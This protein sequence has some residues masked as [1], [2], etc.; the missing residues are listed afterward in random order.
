MS[1]HPEGSGDM[2]AS[3]IP[4]LVANARV[5][6]VRDVKNFTSFLG[7]L[8]DTRRES[9]LIISGC[10][11]LKT[12][13]SIP[14]PKRRSSYGTI[15]RR[16]PR[17]ARNFDA[18]FNSWRR[19]NITIAPPILMP[20]M[21]NPRRDRLKLRSQR[22]ECRAGPG[23]DVA[24]RARR[25]R[26]RGAASNPALAGRFRA[27]GRVIREEQ[28]GLRIFLDLRVAEALKGLFTQLES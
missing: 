9:I 1:V 8:L 14:I 5:A 2:A 24:E 4:N 10:I 15:F 6:A 26:H 19:Q 12:A 11:K 18:T 23:H 13:S 27:E 3:F 22:E 20:T 7:C 25:K 16:R 17:P 21:D 28:D